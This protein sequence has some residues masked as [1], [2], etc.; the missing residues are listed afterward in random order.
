[1]IAGTP[2][3]RAIL[4]AS[5]VAIAGTAPPRAMDAPQLAVEAERI[6]VELATDRV[7]PPDRLEILSVR[8][9]GV[10]PLPAG[11]IDLE[12]IE[13]DGP[14]E[15]GIVRVEL[16][17]AV[18]GV[19]RGTAR[20]SVRGEVRGPVLVASETLARNEPIPADAVEVRDVDL[21]RLAG[22]PVRA[23]DDLDGRVPLRTLG[24]GRTI[25]ADLVGPA[26]VVRRNAPVELRVR[27]GALTVTARGVAKTDGA[28]GDVIPAVNAATGSRLVGRVEADGS[29][30]VLAGEGG[31]R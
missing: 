8:F 31:S 21:T 25:T 16:R 13:V 26:L 29:L 22:E 18:D 14:S 12:P 20:A 4:A 3:R 30:L 17:V 1:V 11:A 7:A 10:D 9:D 27:R 2:F 24:A 6:A 19:P 28:P 23:L 15:S 5:A